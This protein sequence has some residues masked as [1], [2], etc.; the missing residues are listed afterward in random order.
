MEPRTSSIKILYNNKDIS[1]DISKYIKSINYTDNL[2]GEAD[3]L[4]ITLEDRQ[5][6]W[7]SAWM[8][9]KGATLEV[10][11]ITSRWN[12]LESQ[13]DTLRLGYFEIDEIT[14]SEP[15]REVQIKSVSIPD[16]SGLR[17]EERSRSWEK[18]KLYTIASDIATDA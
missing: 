12:N 4:Q 8:P 14:S 15:P 16:N 10:S 13:N 5:G 6:L 9:E 11:I 3:D 7:Q 2:S 1:T 18:T 17:G